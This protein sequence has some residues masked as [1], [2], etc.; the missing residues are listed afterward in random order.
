MTTNPYQSPA[1]SGVAERKDFRTKFWPVCLVSMPGL[2]AVSF[3]GLIIAG[4]PMSP[5]ILQLNFAL[6][7]IG[8]LAMSAFL[9][10][11]FRIQVF[12][13]SIHCFDFWGRYHTVSW[14]DITTARPIWLGLRYLRLDS[15]RRPTIW[16]PLYLH[17]QEEFWVQME[18]RLP[19]ETR[20]HIRS[21]LGV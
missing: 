18:Q 2:M 4:V 16:L 14:E 9:T 17:R 21:V 10:F 20:D 5:S 8:G 1:A 6:S 12:E 7:S 15:V 19:E 3:G 13:K 11:F